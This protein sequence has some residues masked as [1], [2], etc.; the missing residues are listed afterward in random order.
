MSLNVK[1]G[2]SKEKITSV[3]Q[4][5]CLKIA[6]RKKNSV[7]QRSHQV[8]HENNNEHKIKDILHDYVHIV[9]ILASIM[10]LDKMRMAR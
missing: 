8:L 10:I 5:S 6:P 9:G 2:V 4:F 7:L 3:A 1:N